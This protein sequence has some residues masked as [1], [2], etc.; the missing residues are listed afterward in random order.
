M[1][2]FKNNIRSKLVLCQQVEIVKTSHSSLDRLFLFRTMQ[3]RLQVDKDWCYKAS[4]WWVSQRG[5]SEVYLC[6]LIEHF[7]R[8]IKLMPASFRTQTFSVHF[9]RVREERVIPCHLFFSFLLSSI[10]RLP[11]YLLHLDTDTNF[12]CSIALP[13]SCSTQLRQDSREVL[14]YHCFFSLKV[15]LCS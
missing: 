1:P 9:I 10:N 7:V 6:W 4:S 8:L 5:S 14:L 3:D 11:A 15:T 2:Y 13:T 12:L